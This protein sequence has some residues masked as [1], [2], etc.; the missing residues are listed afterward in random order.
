VVITL[1]ARSRDRLAILCKQGRLFEAQLLLEENGTARFRKTRKWTPLFFAVDRGFHSLVEVLLRYDHA[2]WDLEKAY[3]AAIRR[4]RRDLAALILRTPSWDGVIDSVEALSTGDIELVRYLIGA[5]NDLTRSPAVTMAAL[6]NPAGTIKA[7][8]GVG[9]S[10]D[11][12]ADQLRA[13][14]VTHAARDHVMAVV[15][16]LRIGFDPRVPGVY[17]DE[18]DKPREECTALEAAALSNKPALLRMLRPDPLTDDAEMLIRCASAADGREKM[19]LLLDAGFQLNCQENGGS[20]ALH[21]ALARG[22][23]LRCFGKGSVR[24]FKVLEEYEDQI[25]W[26]LE[27]GAVWRGKDK[28]QYVCVRDAFVAVGGE[29]ASRVIGMLREVDAISSSDLAELFRTPRMKVFARDAGLSF[30]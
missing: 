12:V 29:G 22:F 3:S 25:R 6:R 9:I 7:L 1:D 5:G 11:S 16:F 20:P 8:R 28:D 19:E 10:F 24:L 14:M 15:Q 23:I 30:R 2:Q 18:K 17:Y 21:R 26:L 27:L 13:A 4:G